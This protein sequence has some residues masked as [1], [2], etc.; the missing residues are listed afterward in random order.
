M[1]K[2]VYILEIRKQ[3]RTLNKILILTNKIDRN[4]QIKN[5]SALN[6]IILLIFWY[7]ILNDNI[8]YQNYLIFIFNY[9]ILKSIKTIM[10]IKK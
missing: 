10:R 7:E 2:K 9:Y 4:Y 8:F 6:F 3:I 1:I 5:N